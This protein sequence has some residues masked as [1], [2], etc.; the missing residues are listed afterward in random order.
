MP[1]GLT[2][3][4]LKRVSLSRALMLE[5]W[6]GFSYCSSSPPLCDSISGSQELK[7]EKNRICKIVPS[8]TQLDIDDMEIT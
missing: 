7:F 1:T 4:S 2:C 5:F 8:N 6:Q 3:L